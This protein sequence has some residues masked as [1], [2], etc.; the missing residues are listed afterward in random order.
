MQDVNM[1]DFF[2]EIYGYKPKKRGKG[3]EMLVGAVLKILNNSADVKHDVFMRSKYSD[4]TY[5][6]DNLVTQNSDKTFV[7]AK[8]YTESNV[9]VGRPD[10]SKLSGALLHLPVSKG[11]VVSSTDFTKPAINHAEDCHKNPNAKPIDL[12]IIRRSN[13]SDRSGRINTIVLNMNFILPDQ[14][15]ASWT[16]KW[17]KEAMEIFNELGY[18]DGDTITHAIDSFYDANGQVIDTVFNLTRELNYDYALMEAKGR[19]E[20]QQKAHIIV[21]GKLVP[22]EHIDYRIPLIKIERKKEITS[23]EPCIL[24]KS[25]DGFVD[26][27]ITYEQLKEIKFEEQDNA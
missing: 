14:S 24:V 7:E 20:F 16:P 1:D 19:F 21:K 6:I 11:L 13:E 5:Q 15:S 3:Y 9:K 23:G 26:K 8:D 4:D 18:N 25:Q 12:Y 10:V 27:L 22:I 2:C 17:A